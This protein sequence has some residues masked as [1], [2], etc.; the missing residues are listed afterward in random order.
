[1]ALRLLRGTNSTSTYYGYTYL[2]CGYTS[3]CVTIAVRTYYLLRTTY[4]SEVTLGHRIGAG[5]FGEVYQARRSTYYGSTY[6]G[7]TYYG[8]TYY[9]STYF[10]E[11]YQARS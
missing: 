8:S 3:T 10:G 7:S 6:Y 4:Y 5:A 1:M 2:Y 9:G 11:V